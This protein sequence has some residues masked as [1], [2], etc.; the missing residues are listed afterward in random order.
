MIIFDLKCTRQGHVFEAWFGSGEDYARQREAG[1]VSCPLCGDPDVEKAVSAPRLNAKANQQ[2]GRL[3][4]PSASA[5]A[6]G[7][8]ELIAALAAV[9]E[10]LLETS[11]YVGERFAEEAR[12]IHLGERGAR[13]IHGVAT[14]DDAESLLEEGINITPL[15]FPVIDDRIK[16]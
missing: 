10:K 6:A 8:K 12:A 13:S 16:N 1:L 14:K 2:E 3:S 7:M 5:S 15:P 11:D 9:Q 4:V